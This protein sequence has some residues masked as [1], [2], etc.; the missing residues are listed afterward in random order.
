MIKNYLTISLYFL[1]LFSSSIYA[2]GDYNLGEKKSKTCIACHGIDGNSDNKLYP[3]LAGQYQNYLIHA[4][5]SY[6]NGTRKNAIMN[7]FAA[8]LS[9]EDIEDISKFYSEQ[10]GLKVLPLN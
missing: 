10:K 7:G 4:L 1:V 2:G 9:D 8:L 3:R 5:H 6:K